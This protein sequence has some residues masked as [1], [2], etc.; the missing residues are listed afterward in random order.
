M[1]TPTPI[2]SV[3]TVPLPPAMRRRALLRFIPLLVLTSGLL[4]LV[5][6]IPWWLDGQLQVQSEK[7]RHQ[8]QLTLV[9]QR[10][11]NSFQVVVQDLKLLSGN[12]SLM[13]YLTRSDEPHR[14]QVEAQFL[15]FANIRGVY[16]Q[17]RLL[18]HNGMELIRIN[19]SEGRSAVVPA[20][21]R[22]SK[23]HRYY[24][25]QSWAMAPGRI[26]VSKMDL[27]MENGQI[28]HPLKPMIRF[29]VPIADLQGRKRAVV[30][31]NYR[32]QQVLDLFKN[33]M[34]I[35]R[36]GAMLCDADGYWMVGRTPQEEW[37]FMFD[38]GLRF[39]TRMAKTWQEITQQPQGVIE[40]SD[41]LFFFRTVDPISQLWRDHTDTP[42]V[43]AKNYHWKAVSWIPPHA[44]PTPWNSPF[45]ILT[46]ILLLSLAAIALWQLLLGRIKQGYW[47]QEIAHSESRLRAVFDNAAVGV[48]VVDDQGMVRQANA[49]LLR[50]FG[51]QSHGPLCLHWPSFI[52]PEEKLTVEE[53]LA[54]MSRHNKQ[55]PSRTIRHERAGQWWYARTFISPVFN[56]DVATPLA[57]LILED[58]S[59]WVEADRK[60]R[61]LQDQLLH[62]GR[63]SQMGELAASLAHEVNTPLGTIVNYAQGALRRMDN[64]HCDTKQLATALRS[65]DGQA[66]RI[67]AIIS[68][69]RGFMTKQEVPPLKRFNMLDLLQ[70]TRTFL[71]PRLERT[72]AEVDIQPKVGDF[73]IKADPIQMEQL[74]MNLLFNAVEAMEFNTEHPRQVSIQCVAQSPGTLQLVIVDNGPPMAADALEQ[75]QEPFY[76]TKPYGMGMGLAICRT[77]VE[78]H[79][80]DLQMAP[81]PERGATVTIL[82]PTGLEQEHLV[83]EHDHE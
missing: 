77:I 57:M 14:Q 13:R 40:N 24:F 66:R 48:A 17:I 82:L 56:E 51:M 74:V 78:N 58:V 34:T 28:Q 12:P 27:N 2:H 35:N 79:G 49:T 71:E 9:K 59:E 41:G 50:M 4:F 42:P 55:A 6:W 45:W 38:H 37:G 72:Q 47:V 83:L 11:D 61:E 19:R 36:R 7:L 1:Q 18:D 81:N 43:W 22:Q 75:A 30:V 44:W 16:D 46:Y 76:T 31:L 80:G 64:G 15:R 29:A 63:V 23:K 52:H 26:Y 69:V 10:L 39:D 25:K 32:A 33:A 62:M 65:I 20:Y 54:G 73:F 21:K 5:M 68:R 8:A 60:E 70:D 3:H 67:S 53:L